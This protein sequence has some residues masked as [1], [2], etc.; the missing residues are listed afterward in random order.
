MFCTLVLFWCTRC[1]TCPDSNERSHHTRKMAD[2][3]D[4]MEPEGDLLSEASDT[5]QLYMRGARG[6]G[7]ALHSQREARACYG[8]GCVVSLSLQGHVSCVE[9]AV[10]PERRVPRDFFRRGSGEWLRRRKGAL[11]PCS[12]A[13]GGTSEEEQTDSR[14]SQEKSDLEAKVRRLRWTRT[15]EEVA[16]VPEFWRRRWW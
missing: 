5:C 11:P 1:C 7:T 8:Q 10:R 14:S 9:G 2:A 12:A 13:Q 4:E 3:A 15:H 6:Q 16:R